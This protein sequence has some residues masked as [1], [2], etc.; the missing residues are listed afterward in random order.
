VAAAAA[1]AVPQLARPAA[2]RTGPERRCEHGWQIPLAR[3]CENGM[4]SDT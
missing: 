3:G 2:P 1:A 4:V